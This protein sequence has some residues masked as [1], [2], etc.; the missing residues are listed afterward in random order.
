[1]VDGAFSCRGRK[2]FAEESAVEHWG[3]GEGG[4]GVS[5]LGGE[6]QGCG[7]EE[8]EVLGFEAGEGVGGVAAICERGEG[9]VEVLG[10]GGGGPVG[11]L[12]EGGAG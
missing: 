12:P 3:P 8:L 7:A 11:F 5:I 2:R 9:V 6:V 4:G 1:M 10:F